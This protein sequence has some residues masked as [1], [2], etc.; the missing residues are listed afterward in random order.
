MPFGKR[1]VAT[2][3]INNES[4]NLFMVGSFP[5]GRVAGAEVA[6]YD[7]PDDIDCDACILEW[8]WRGG[9]KIVRQCA[10]I[11]VTGGDDTNCV[12]QCQN[13]GICQRG[14]CVCPSGYTGTFCENAPG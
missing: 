6:F 2:D 14:A 8:I 3:G 7:I 1:D 9:D 5:C 4:F 10:D 11:T 13:G 12:G